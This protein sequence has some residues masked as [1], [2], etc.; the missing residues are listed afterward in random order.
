MIG[1]DSIS[2]FSI[3]ETP[4]TS[5]SPGLVLQCQ[6]DVEATND[7]RFTIQPRYEVFL[8]LDPSP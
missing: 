1:E 5:A 2:E 7:S 3:G 4:E 8:T 6:F